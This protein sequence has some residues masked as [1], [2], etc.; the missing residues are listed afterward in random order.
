MD[1]PSKVLAAHDLHAGYG[2]ID[3]LHGI[4]LH[5][6][7]GEVVALLGANGAGKTTTL[8]A[9]AG[10][11]PSRGRLE[12]LGHDDRAP[13]HVQTRRGMR[14]LPDDRGIVRALSVADNLRLAGVDRDDA[15]E[16]GPELEA[17]AGRRAGHL[18]GGEQQILALT[19]AIASAPALLMADELSFGL[20]PVVV[21]RM[22]RLARLAA[23]RGA[24][25]LLVEQYASQALAVADRAYVL[26]RGRVALQGPAAD[27]AGDLDA[28]ERSYLGT[29]G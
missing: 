9:F 5:V 2:K 3:V 1:G 23:E 11:L 16:L 18:S 24:A 19:R 14:Y 21:S 17:L 15:Y 22:L 20:A 29:V 10:L 12:V 6:D 4:D 8:R 7:A 27:L 25:V 13:L 28:I 26:Q